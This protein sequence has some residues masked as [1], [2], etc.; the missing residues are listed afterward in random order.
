VPLS[1]A[2]ITFVLSRQI[3]TGKSLPNR[4]AATRRIYTLLAHEAM[5]KRRDY[6]PSKLELFVAYQ[7]E[8]CKAAKAHAAAWGIPKD[9]LKALLELQTAYLAAHKRYAD[10]LN[11]SKLDVSAHDALRKAYTACIRSLAQRFMARNPV[12]SATDRYVLGL[13][14]VTERRKKLDKIKDGALC[15]PKALGNTEVRFSC[16]VPGS[17]G[18][19]RLHPECHAVEV[20]YMVVDSAEMPR[21]IPFGSTGRHTSSKAQFT[22]RIG[23]PGQWLYVR[24][25]W[26]NTSD[27]GR[28]GSWSEVQLVLIH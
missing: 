23:R 10:T 24:A 25:R 14:F 7:A 16:F 15:I 12:M 3:S 17:G 5:G 21:G 9:E 8:F 26:V 11:R 19:P 4:L 13:E 6:I 28:S 20:E 22:L 27:P 1:V 2:L 18:R